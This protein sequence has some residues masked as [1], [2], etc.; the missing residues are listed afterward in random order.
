MPATKPPPPKRFKSKK[1]TNDGPIVP[2]V[3]E[4]TRVDGDKRVEE[5]HQF[6]A[7]PQLDYKDAVGFIKGQDDQS[8]MILVRVDRMIRSALIDSDGTPIK[9]QPAPNDKGDI[10]GPD[11]AVIDS[12][13][14][15]KLVAFDAGSSKRR[16]AHLMDRDDDLIVDIEQ[17]VEVIEYL[18]EQTSGRPT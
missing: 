4:F 17:M 5:E 16:W 6:T 14:A 13:T 11:G 9:W 3:V 12:E 2:F 8:G 7:Q 15:G 18:I 10:V 1:K